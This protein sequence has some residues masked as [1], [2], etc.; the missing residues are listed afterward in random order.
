MQT[1]LENDQRKVYETTE[2]SRK[3][4]KNY[5]FYAFQKY[6]NI[7]RP[8]EIGHT[9]KTVKNYPKSSKVILKTTKNLTKFL[10]FKHRNMLFISGPNQLAHAKII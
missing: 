1:L 5:N 3:F 9:K 6:P 10:I 4:F 2:K 8:P 7:Y